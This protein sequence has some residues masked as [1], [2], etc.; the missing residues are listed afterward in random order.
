[1]VS[2]IE[3]F[4]GCHCRFLFQG[5]QFPVHQSFRHGGHGPADIPDGQRL[6]LLLQVAGR[7]G[8]QAACKQDAALGVD[9][10]GAL[11]QLFSASLP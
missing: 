10:L 1:M 5:L 6:P 8:Q 4:P 2:H 7:S 9:T 11:Q 3:F